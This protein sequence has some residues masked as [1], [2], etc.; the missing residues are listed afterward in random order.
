[1]SS[2]TVLIYMPITVCRLSVS[3]G[4]IPFLFSTALWGLDFATDIDVMLENSGCIFSTLHGSN[5]T[6]QTLEQGLNSTQTG[7]Y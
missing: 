7:M 4:G 5:S 2:F 3:A 6:D 1:M